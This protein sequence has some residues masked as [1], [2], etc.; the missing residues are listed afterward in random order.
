M[1]NRSLFEN[2]TE[3][4]SSTIQWKLEKVVID[5]LYGVLKKSVR[6]ELG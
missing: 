6:F 4:N 3:Y 5:I 1:L 2:Y